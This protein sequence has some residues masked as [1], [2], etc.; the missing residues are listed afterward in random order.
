MKQTLYLFYSE[1]R[2][3][4]FL[5]DCD[6]SEAEGYTLI[7]E[8]EIEFDV[9]HVDEIRKLRVDGYRKVIERIQAAAQIDVDRVQGKI[10]DLL[11]LTHEG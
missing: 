6:M 5:Y 3:G 8:I 1:L 4:F 11:Y 7:R 9:P 2:D 10:N